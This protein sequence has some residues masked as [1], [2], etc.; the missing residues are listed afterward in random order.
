MQNLGLKQGQ[1]N[2][3]FI[4]SSIGNLWARLQFNYTK[5]E[6]ERSSNIKV[7]YHI[8]KIMLMVQY[9]SHFSNNCTGSIVAHQ[10]RIHMYFVG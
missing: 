8:I 1:L 7:I 10:G 3:S 2:S 6:L 4:I 5:H 9:K